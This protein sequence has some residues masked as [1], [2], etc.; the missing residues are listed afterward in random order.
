MM[1]ISES[2]DKIPPANGDRFKPVAFFQRYGREIGLP[3]IVVALIV[4]F[5][6]NSEVFLSLAN[7]RNIGVRTAAA[8]AG[9]LIFGQTFAVL[10]AGL[11]LSVGSIV[12]LVSIVG[13]IVMRNYGVPAG[14][15]RLRC[16]RRG[17]R[18]GQWNRDHAAQ[19][20]SLHR[21]ARHDVHRFGSRIEPECGAWR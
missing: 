20:V 15:D 1:G 8:L 14:Y 7:F 16:H 9:G 5:A 19:G 4:F 6:A 3:V 21:D 2:A 17:R 11:D 13:A 18:A 12:A 10:T